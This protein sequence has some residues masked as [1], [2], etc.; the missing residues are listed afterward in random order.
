MEFHVDSA[1]AALDKCHELIR[2]GRADLFR[3]QSRDWPR[4]APTLLRSSGEQLDAAQ[5]EL[6][7]FGEWAINVPQM[8]IYKGDVPSIIAIAQHYGFPTTFLD[9][10]TSPEVAILFS[11]P[12]STPDDN[13]SVVYCFSAAALEKITAGQLIRINVDNLWRLE[14]Q[15]GLF[16]QFLDETLTTTLREMAIRIYF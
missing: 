11:K 9:L 15:S 8:A 1:Q 2:A 4:L 6:Q 16:F 13:E 3:G 14:A 7:R 12:Q 10:T 5:A